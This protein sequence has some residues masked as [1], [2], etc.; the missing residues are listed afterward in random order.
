MGSNISAHNVGSFDLILTYNQ[1]LTMET[2]NN[3]CLP[4]LVLSDSTSEV[5][6]EPIIFLGPLLV[7][8]YE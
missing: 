5:R 4:S 6:P 1:T 8:Y 7:L 2:I 3:H